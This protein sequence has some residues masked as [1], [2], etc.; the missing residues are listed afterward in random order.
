MAF[1]TDALRM[2]RIMSSVAVLPL[3]FPF[4]VVLSSEAACALAHCVE[5]SG[6]SPPSCWT[7]RVPT[8]PV[9]ADTRGARVDATS[10]PSMHE[11]VSITSD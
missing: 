3:P 7:V 6:A 10:A 8:A 1:S 2:M 5:G 9:D 11:R 4:A